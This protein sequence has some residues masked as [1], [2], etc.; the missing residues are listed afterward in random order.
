MAIDN[1]ARQSSG[2]KSFFSRA[3]LHKDKSSDR[4][5]VS[6]ESRLVPENA[7]I[8]GSSMGS[9]TSRR[10]H[11]SSITSRS[12]LER[13]GSPEA[14]PSGLS[15]TAG[16]ITSIPYDSV[17][18]DVRTPIPVDYLPRGD[19]KAVRREPLPHH[20]NKG[21]GDFHQYPAFNPQ[22]LPTNH[23]SHPSGPRPPPGSLSG[24]PGERSSS[25]P[26]QGSVSTASRGNGV[27]PGNANLMSTVDPMNP[28]TSFDQASVHS[29]FSS[30]TRESSIF[31]SSNSSHTAIPQQAQ[32]DSHPLAHTVSRS[33]IASRQ[34]QHHGG[35]FAH[36]PSA[37]N[38]SS[39]FSHDAFYLARPSDDRIIE[40]Q[41]L[42]L[43]HKRGSQN[44][45]EQAR[46]QMLAY[47]AAKKWTLIYQDKLT[48][49]QGEQK[50]RTYA[51][52][53]IIGSDGQ[54]TAMGRA[55]EDGS[56]EWYVKKVMDDTISAK[57]L[58]S[59]SVSLRTQ[60]IRFVTTP[61]Q[62]GHFLGLMGAAG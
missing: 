62:L 6:D 15:M 5:T 48:D 52:Q 10:T 44:I 4:R 29:S 55:D 28:R 49:F 46:R 42:A 47:P 14:D 61:L 53:T 30:A 13:P 24:S 45:P 8:G 35:F 38:S 1:K 18:E 34:S 26:R 3:K 54:L 33:S 19:Q 11:R 9:R 23:G 20:L 41:F 36:N 31:S 39:S 32:A 16:V 22:S 12:E 56:P 7:S 60:P 58:S 21:G 40:E 25:I 37:L 27:Y 43:M 2:G 59:L 17:T 51:R 50:R 57:Q